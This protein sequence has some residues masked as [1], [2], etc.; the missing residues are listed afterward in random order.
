MNYREKELSALMHGIKSARSL[1][2]RCRLTAEIYPRYEIEDMA[3]SR[4]HFAR[5]H[6]Y[7]QLVRAKRQELNG[8]QNAHT[9]R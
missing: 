6:D 4:R 1:A 5:A 3:E 2:H 8:E 9:G 7:I